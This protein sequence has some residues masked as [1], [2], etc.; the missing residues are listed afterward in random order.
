MEGEKFSAI[1]FK[2]NTCFPKIVQKRF[3]LVELKDVNHLF[4]HILMMYD[5]IFFS[6]FYSLFLSI[7]HLSM[8]FIE[9]AWNVEFRRHYCSNFIVLDCFFDDQFY[10]FFIL[11]FFNISNKNQGHPMQEKTSIHFVSI[12]RDKCIPFYVVRISTIYS[13]CMF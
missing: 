13:I 1:Q 2:M 6:V 12:Y 11:F 10:T 8:Q 4:F 3:S 7:E 5:F 9:E